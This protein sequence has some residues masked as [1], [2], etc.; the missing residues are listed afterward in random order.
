[1]CDQYTEQGIKVFRLNDYEWFAGA[2]AQAVLAYALEQW[3][4]KGKPTDALNDGMYDEDFDRPCDLDAS[5]LNGAEDAEDGGKEM[6][7][8]RE[9][10]RRELAKGVT[11]PAFFC[12]IEG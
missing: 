6:I 9:S 4:F 10:I 7:T 3:G 11:F 2:D 12:G 8:Y 5:T 1:M